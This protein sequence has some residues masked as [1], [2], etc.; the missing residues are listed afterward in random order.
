MKWAKTA[1]SCA[2]TAEAKNAAKAA[3]IEEDRIL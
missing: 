2:C 1:L 3:I